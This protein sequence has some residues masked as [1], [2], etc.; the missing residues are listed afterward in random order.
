MNQ[1]RSSAPFST[2]TLQQAVGAHPDVGQEREKSQ[3]GK[4]REDPVSA[5]NAATHPADTGGFSWSSWGSQ[6]AAARSSPLSAL[7]HLQVE[8]SMRL[9]ELRVRGLPARSKS[10]CVEEEEASSPLLNSELAARCFVKKP[11]LR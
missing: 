11:V 2:S 7:C 1:M 8:Q 5:S 4:N 9:A 3:E 10:A 6:G